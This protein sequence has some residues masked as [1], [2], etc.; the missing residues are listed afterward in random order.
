MGLKRTGV[1]CFLTV[2][3]SGQYLLP[4]QLFHKA[5][6]LLWK[7]SLLQQR[8][9][10][11]ASNAS[12]AASYAS[13]AASRVRAALAGIELGYERAHGMKMPT[14]SSGSGGAG[15]I[16]MKPQELRL[17]FGKTNDFGMTELDKPAMLDFIAKTRS[18]GIPA[19]K[20]AAAV[21]L[22]DGDA[23]LEAFAQA[24]RGGRAPAPARSPSP[25]KTAPTAI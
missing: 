17:Y 1:F 13:A 18:L 25:K 21:Y 14:A 22:K 10:A 3:F 12:A 24:V 2:G 15:G 19:E 20:N 5:A 9:K 4:A 23:G 6:P 8:G 11:A 7:S 16:S